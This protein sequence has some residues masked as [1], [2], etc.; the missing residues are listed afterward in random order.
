[1]PF[2]NGKARAAQTAS[3]ARAAQRKQARDIALEP[4]G[5]DSDDCVSEPPSK[6]VRVDDDTGAVLLL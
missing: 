5:L 6:S 4:S 3:L 1:M 2:K